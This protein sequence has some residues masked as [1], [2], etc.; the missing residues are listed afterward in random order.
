MARTRS[1]VRKPSQQT[2]SI[3]APLHPGTDLPRQVHQPEKATRRSAPPSPA[4]PRSAKAGARDAGRGHPPFPSLPPR[5]RKTGRA[6]GPAGPQTCADSQDN[7]SEPCSRSS[8]QEDCAAADSVCSSLNFSAHATRERQS[9]WSDHDDGRH[10]GDD[11]IDRRAPVARFHRRRHVGAE[12]RQLDVLVEHGDRLA[13]RDE[14]PPA[15]EAHHRVPHQPRWPEAGNS[16]LAKRCQRLR[17]VHA[18]SFLQ[19]RRDRDERVVKAEGHVPRL[20]GKRWRRCWRIPRPAGCR[21]T[22]R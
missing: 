18:G 16:S 1:S 6:P 12:A 9:N 22:G 13:L 15:A 8:I 21:E 11:R 10:H 19:L 20:R 7:R 5:P 14:E 17:P 2:C 4:R 3:S